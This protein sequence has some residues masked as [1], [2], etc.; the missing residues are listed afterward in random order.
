V[1]A[2]I[3]IMAALG[4]LFFENFH[5]DVLIKVHDERNAQEICAITM[6]ATA[7]GADVLVIN[8]TEATILNL[9]EGREGK[10]GTFKGKTFRLANFH[11]D[12]IPGAQ[13][14]LAWSDGML[15]Y[16]GGKA[17]E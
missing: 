11:P 14:Y 12:Q 4:S 3:G 2:V 16:E 15:K 7:S 17:S 8:D 6:G 1:I 9:I 10:S 13:K 5:R